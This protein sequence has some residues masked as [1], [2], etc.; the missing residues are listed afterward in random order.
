MKKSN[1]TLA[2]LFLQLFRLFGRIFL[3][4]TNIITKG[5]ILY[6]LTVLVFPKRIPFHIY[7][8]YIA[9][10]SFMKYR[11]YKKYKKDENIN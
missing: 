3:A 7:L 4:L 10:S 1:R 8:P 2:L 11:K 9:T 6:D 5:H